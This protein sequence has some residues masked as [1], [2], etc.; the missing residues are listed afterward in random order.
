[1]KTVYMCR[2]RAKA[3]YADLNVQIYSSNFFPS[4][5]EKPLLD[6]II[7]TKW[8][9]KHTSRVN[10]LSPSSSLVSSA[11]KSA[12]DIDFALS[13]CNLITSAS[14]SAGDSSSLD[15]SCKKLKRQKTYIKHSSDRKKEQIIK[16]FTIL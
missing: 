16:T 1:M 11:P 4:E 2:K 14:S 7:I 3:H 10:S 12:I 8:F 6:N 15:C 13:F 5:G 9:S